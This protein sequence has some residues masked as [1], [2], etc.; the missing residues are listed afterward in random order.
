MA[1]KKKINK[2]NG[3]K[4]IEDVGPRSWTAAKTDDGI[5]NRDIVDYH[6]KQGCSTPVFVGTKIRFNWLKSSI[7]IYLEM[8]FS[9]PKCTGR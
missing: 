6:V 2:R 5:N 1:K 3:G 7:S 9:F 8:S 4:E